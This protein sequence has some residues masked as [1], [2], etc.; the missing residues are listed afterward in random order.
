[1]PATFLAFLEGVTG[2]ALPLAFL[3][4][5]GAMEMILVMVIGLLLFG[6]KGLPDMARTFGRMVREFKKATAGVENEMKRVMNEEPPPPVKARPKPSAT[7]AAS[8]SASGA[9]AATGA[10]TS[11]SPSPGPAQGADV[12]LGQGQK[13]GE[14]GGERT[15]PSGV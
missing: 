15:P 14:A 12:S 3:E 9:G 11:A 2:G 10:V 8:V 6:G 7:V 4:G 13:Q 1:M 5:I